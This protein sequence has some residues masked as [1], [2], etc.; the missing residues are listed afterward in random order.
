MKNNSQQFE[1]KAIIKDRLKYIGIIML[2]MLCF[3]FWYNHEEVEKSDW[4]QSNSTIS[5]DGQDMDE[6]FIIC[7]EAL[8]ISFCQ[9]QN[10]TISAGNF[11]CKGNNNLFF[12]KEI[13]QSCIYKILQHNMLHTS[14]S[15]LSLQEENGYYTY[16]QGKLLI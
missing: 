6:T 10:V 2:L 13:S 15:Y 5:E 1:N 7:R 16:R 12:F 9:P 11:F 4:V 8:P 3:S 14:L